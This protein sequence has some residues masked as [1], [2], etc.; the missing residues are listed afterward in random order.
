MKNVSKTTK[1]AWA[2]SARILLKTAA[3][4]RRPGPVFFKSQRG[5][6]LRLVN[7]IM[8]EFRLP[9]A[10]ERGLLAVPPPMSLHPED[11][12]SELPSGVGPGALVEVR[13]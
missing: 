3:S 13:L 10:T 5:T 11:C 9:T 8:D 4:R 1:Q 6:E 12:T 7:S 2:D